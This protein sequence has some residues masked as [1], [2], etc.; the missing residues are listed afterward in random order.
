M[1]V[2]GALFL[3][4]RGVFFHAPCVMP[5]LQ[6]CSTLSTVYMLAGNH[7]CVVCFEKLLV[8]LSRCLCVCVLALPAR[9]SK[10]C[11]STH[12]YASLCLFSPHPS[13][14]PVFVWLSVHLCVWHRHLNVLSCR[15]C[16]Y[17][18]FFFVFCPFP[19]MRM[20]LSCQRQ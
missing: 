15:C 17:S 14:Y 6:Q 18:C 7:G 11:I 9:F 5:L 10:P 3:K 4:G 1:G 16:L 2:S 8:F 12:L 13:L 20:R 19:G